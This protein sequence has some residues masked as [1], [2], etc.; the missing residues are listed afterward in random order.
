MQIKPTKKQIEA[1]QI[2]IQKDVR[3]ILYGGAVRGAKTYWLFLEL[4][5]YCFK[6][7]KSRWAYVRKD[8]QRIKQTSLITFNEFLDC[9]FSQY[10]KSFNQDTF[11]VTFYNKSQL[12]FM[13]ENIDKDPELNRFKGLEVNGFGA[14]EVNEL[15]YKTYQ[16]MIERAGSW[17]HSPNVPIKIL[18]TCNPARGWVKDEFYDKYKLN[19]LESHKAYI[20]ANIYDNPHVPGQYLKSLESLDAVN[21]RLFV[22]G[23]WDAFSTNRE[24][25][26]NF[27]DSRH[28]SNLATY[29]KDLL[30]YLSFDFNIDPATCAVFQQTKDYIYMID[31]IHLDSSSL[32]MLCDVI[33]SRPYYKKIFKITGDASGW[34]R[35]KA[36]YDLSSMYDLILKSLNFDID[37]I[38]A[39]RS[40]PSVK[41]SRLLIN[42][43]LENANILINP[44]CTN[45]IK[46]LQ[47]VEVDAKGDID[48]TKKH[49]THHLDTFRY[50]FTTYHYDFINLDYEL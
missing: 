36:T 15:D 12:I 11:T 34:A 1:H 35:E 6:Y 43:M 37:D 5:T 27:K 10:V 30:V 41:K 2:A 24:F 50:F 40:N 16:K 22:D 4:F 49:L 38:D 7:E 32:E 3:D 29:N 39:P 19:K 33:K 21:K 17:F 13:G 46:D 20:P 18:M 28:V 42:C 45:T 48:K 14:D 44:S 25:A 31:E 8:L 9:G 26:Y 47:Q 23:D